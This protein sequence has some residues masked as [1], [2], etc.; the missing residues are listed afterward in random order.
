[1]QPDMRRRF[2]VVYT[3]AFMLGIGFYAGSVQAEN[4]GSTTIAIRQALGAPLAGTTPTTGQVLKF[5]GT[6]W[7]PGTDA[8][9]AAATG[10][11]QA[12]DGT[13]GAPAYSFA[14]DTNTGV[15]RTGADALGFSAG[16]TN[17]V[18]VTAVGLV[19][20]VGSAGGVQLS[21]DLALF[22]NGR[23]SIGSP[24]NGNLLL[25]D[26]AGTSFGLLQFGGA[27][28]SYPSLKRSAAGFEA[29][30]AD[31]SAS[32]FINVSQLGRGSKT[33][34]DQTGDAL[35]IVGGLGTGSA[36]GG[37][38]KVRSGFKTTSGTTAHAETD[39]YTI[40]GT[41]VLSDNVGTTFA[42]ISCASGT[43]TGATCF[44]T[45]R[46]YDGT[47]LQCARGSFRVAANNKAGTITTTIV[48]D[49]VATQSPVGTL[50][51]AASI[52]TGAGII[53]LRITS[54]TSLTATTHDITYQVLA[55]SPAITV[56]SIP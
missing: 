21:Q 18:S 34:T 40:G 53:N 56:T 47:D 1:M 41:R 15:Y 26:T 14:N 23:S 20:E 54:N 32:T 31:D 5:D 43:V 44:W 29:R 42:T 12:D 52:G 49:A 27:T 6:R 10:P 39:R 13:A 11:F 3:L 17:R 37:D 35:R 36:L 46:V 22:W 28:S 45:V 4:P 7:A 2:L 8:S 9:G 25:R 33:G 55:D 48:E 38:I 24:V 16:G 50:V 30:L 19:V 51:A